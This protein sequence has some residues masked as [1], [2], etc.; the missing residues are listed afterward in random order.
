MHIAHTMPSHGHFHTPSQGHFH[1]PS[2]GHFHTMPSH[3]NMAFHVKQKICGGVP[4]GPKVSLHPPSITFGGPSVSLQYPG[5]HG[6][7]RVIVC[8]P[9]RTHVPPFNMDFSKMQK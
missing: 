7:P 2:Q 4:S 3:G 5:P 6:G 8:P 1:T 9:P